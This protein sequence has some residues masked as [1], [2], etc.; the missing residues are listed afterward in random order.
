MH[1]RT[2]S[3]VKRQPIEWEKISANLLSDKGLMSIIFKNSYNPT[4]TTKY[5]VTSLKNEQ[6]N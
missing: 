4:E 6:S 5:Q 2:Q 1:Q 3:T